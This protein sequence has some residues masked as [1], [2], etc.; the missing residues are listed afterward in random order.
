M[1]SCGPAL[2][3]LFF[4]L[5]FGHTSSLQIFSCRMVAAN[6]ACICL[7]P[8]QDSSNTTSQ[9]NRDI[10]KTQADN[11]MT[12]NSTVG[13]KKNNNNWMSINKTE[14]PFCTDWF[15]IMLKTKHFLCAW[16]PFF[17]YSSITNG[18]VLITRF[19]LY[20]SIVGSRKLTKAI[21][22]LYNYA[23]LYWA[24]LYAQSYANYA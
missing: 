15:V 3:F 2:F 14:A 12:G 4:L 10:Q 5:A 6:S 17:V 8:Q 19:F 20:I 23:V 16:F 21:Q 9:I 13:K 11:N 7:G 1:W 22:P 24:C 18:T